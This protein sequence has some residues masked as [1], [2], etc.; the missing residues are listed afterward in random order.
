MSPPNPFKIKVLFHLLAD[1][2]FFSFSDVDFS[3]VCTKKIVLSALVI[4]LLLLCP[5]GGSTVFHSNFWTPQII[6]FF[7]PDTVTM[8]TVCVSFVLFVF[9]QWTQTFGFM[10]CFVSGSFILIKFDGSA[11]PVYALPGQDISFHPSLD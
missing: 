5:G 10:W 4:T 3:V 7:W 6:C 8:A 1:R 9:S 2:E 11:H